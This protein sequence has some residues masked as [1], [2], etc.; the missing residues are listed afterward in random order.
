MR[1]PGLKT[2]RRVVRQIR[3]RLLGG[4]IILGYHRISAEGKDP[5]LMS[6]SPKNLTDQL[7]VIRDLST[8]ISM[9]AIVQVLH[10]FVLTRLA[11]EITMYDVYDDNLY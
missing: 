4:A 1:I 3:S 7:T 9:Q 2:T 11:L 8:P 10:Y 5:F 6:V